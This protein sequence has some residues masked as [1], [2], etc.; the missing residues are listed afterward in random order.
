M[1]LVC[2]ASALHIGGFSWRQNPIPMT[3]DP[4]FIISFLTLSQDSIASMFQRGEGF[5][6]G[7]FEQSSAQDQEEAESWTDAERFR[8]HLEHRE[9]PPGSKKLGG[10]LQEAIERGKEMS[11]EAQ[12]NSE[13]EAAPY[14]EKR[15]TFDFYPETCPADP[16]KFHSERL[17]RMSD[18]TREKIAWQRMKDRVAER[19]RL[20][21]EEPHRLSTFLIFIFHHKLLSWHLL[22]SGITSW[23][24][25]QVFS[26]FNHFSYLHCSV[27]I[28]LTTDLWLGGLWSIWG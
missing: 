12:E 19:S 9:K 21:A 5:W 10:S 25:H 8:A 15:D 24:Y 23:S 1:S 4:C 17:R 3:M 18:R 7:E 27:R 28:H 2:F 26:F 6:E 22:T 13:E 20:E 11:A 16:D 14:K